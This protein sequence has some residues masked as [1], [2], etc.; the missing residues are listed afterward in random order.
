MVPNEIGPKSVTVYNLNTKFHQN[1]QSS[2]RD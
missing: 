2:F 1:L